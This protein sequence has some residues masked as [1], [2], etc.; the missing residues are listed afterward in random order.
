ARSLAAALTGAVLRR[1]DFRVPELATVDL[2][3]QP[4]VESLARRKHLLRRNGERNALHSHLTMEG[5]WHLYRHGSRWRRPDHQARVVLETEGWVAVG[6]ALGVVEL[7]ARDAE[8]DAVGHLGPDL[9]GPDWDA[10]EA[11]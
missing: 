11:V 6:F 3:G 7:L 5:S 4:A 9:L 10:Q 2:A 1:T 8:D